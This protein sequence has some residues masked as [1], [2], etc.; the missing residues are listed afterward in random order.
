[1]IGKKYQYFRISNEILIGNLIANFFSNLITDIIFNFNTTG[2]SIGHLNKLKH[3]DIALFFIF[4]TIGCSILLFYEIPTR[5]CL[6][7]TLTKRL[8][9][10]NSNRLDTPYP[11]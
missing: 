9:P 4:V 2:L 7:K 11:E 6:K 8:L 5:K 10:L 1:M 3:L